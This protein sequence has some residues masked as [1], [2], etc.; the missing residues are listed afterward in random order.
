MLFI[1][2]LP[3]MEKK[4]ALV[5]S[6]GGAKGAFQVGALRYI[7]ENVMPAHPDFRFQIIA[8]VSVGSLN[9]VMLA[10][11]EFPALLNL[12]NHLRSKDIYRG[13]INVAGIAWR[14]LRHK[15][16]LLSHEPLKDL[17]NKHVSLSKIDSRIA[18]R[19]GAVSLNTGEYYYFSPEGFQSDKDFRKAILSS[20]LM[21][22]VWE[23][24]DSF[25]SLGKK[26]TDMV[27]GGIRNSSPLKDVVEFDPDE[28][29]IINCSP[30]GKPLIPDPD[31]A[32]NILQIAKRSLVEIATN[33]IFTGD[34]QE[35]LKTNALVRQAREKG[36]VL[37]NK[38]GRPYKVFKTILINPGQYLGD[39]FNFEQSAVQPR[40][41]LGYEAAQ[42]AFAGYDPEPNE[43]LITNLDSTNDQLQV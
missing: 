29:V 23:P 11:N 35:Y 41:Q 34:L 20:A 28:I 2:Y 17:I 42:K 21:P 6:G 1:S 36:V 25:S 15:R 18:F 31:A 8:G 22:V 13:K 16:S 4:I 14:L 19:A 26:F 37:T 12:W 3:Q 32:R 30:F 5:L 7:Y 10:Q 39:V 27:D 38:N 43:R 24:V 40:M 33:E 9:G